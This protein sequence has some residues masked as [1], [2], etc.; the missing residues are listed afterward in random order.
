[1]ISRLGAYSGLLG[2]RPA[3]LAQNQSC[4]SKYALPRHRGVR[5]GV[6]SSHF[7]WRPLC[8]SLKSYHVGGEGKMEPPDS[9]P[10]TRISHPPLFRR[11]TEKLGLSA[12]SAPQLSCILSLVL[13]GFKTPNLGMPRWLTGWA[14]VMILGSWDGVLHQVP[15]MEPASPFACLLFKIIKNR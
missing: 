14:Q 12:F 2:E 4:P 11:L 1:M 9:W 7:H 6:N 10:W 8:C 3:V 15:C 5:C 13:L